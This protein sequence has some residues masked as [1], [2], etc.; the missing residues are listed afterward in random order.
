[1]KEMIASI[2]RLM[3]IAAIAGVLFSPMML[4]EAMAQACQTT[5]PEAP[6][7]CSGGQTCCSDGSCSFSCVTTPEMSDYLAMA[8]VIVTGGMIY[9]FR[10][11]ALARA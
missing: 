9:Y 3:A 2:S 4:S 11:R 8:F 10:R 6:G 1:M 7:Y 5:T